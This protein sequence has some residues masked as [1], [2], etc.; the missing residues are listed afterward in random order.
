MCYESWQTGEML[1]PANLNSMFTSF[2]NSSLKACL[3][4]HCLAHTTFPRNY[5][6][7]ET[8]TSKVMCTTWHFRRERRHAKVAK[9]CD[10][11]YPIVLVDTTESTLHNSCFGKCQIPIRPRVQGKNTCLLKHKSVF[12]ELKYFS[13]RRVESECWCENQCVCQLTNIGVRRPFPLTK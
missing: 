6:F 13:C 4:G 7:P 12:R 8:L 1:D 10:F 3:F 2:W 9:M 5:G 11:P